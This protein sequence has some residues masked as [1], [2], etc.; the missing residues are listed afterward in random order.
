M[1]RQINELV[2][3]L[4]LTMGVVHKLRHAR[5]QL[6]GV[7]AARP[8]LPDEL[9]RIR[10]DDGKDPLSVL[11]CGIARA[12]KTA[13]QIPQALSPLLTIGDRLSIKCP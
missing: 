10:D 9:V 6:C 2:P 1:M 12:L 11:S 5:C 13:K 4:I 7:V 8:Q 3:A